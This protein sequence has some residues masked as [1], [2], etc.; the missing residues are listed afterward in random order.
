MLYVEETMIPDVW[1]KELYCHHQLQ[2]VQ[3]IWLKNIKMQWH[4]VV[5]MEILIYLL[6]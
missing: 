3:D 1:G 2:V 6:Q 4:F 5:V